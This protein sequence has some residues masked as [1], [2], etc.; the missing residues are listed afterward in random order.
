MKNNKLDP[1][2]PIYIISKGRAEYQYTSRALDKLGLKHRIAVEEHEY[3]L[4]AEALGGE[5]KL[6][7]LP[8]SNHGKGSGP[9]RNFCW[10][11][12]IEQGA[13]RHWL[14]DDN[15]F[16][17]SRFH[18]NKK[19]RVYTGSLF[20]S[21]E[22]FVDR[23]T[24]VALAGPQYA[25]FVA[26]SDKYAPVMLNS[27]LMSCIL[28]K[29]D[30]DFRWRCRYNED[31]DLS[32]RA[33]KQGYTTMVFYHLLQYKA[34]TQSI[35]GG[36]TTEL[37]GEGTYNKSKMLALLHPDCVR[38]VE[39]YGRV[40]HHVDLRPFQHILPILKDDVEIEPGVNEYGLKYVEGYGTEHQKDAIYV[41]RNR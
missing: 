6:L 29:N 38:V 23:Y 17:F 22:D 32:L 37:Y 15:I 41:P 12:S 36:N 14:M 35:P 9:A 1:K 7:A 18:H 33:L 11:H 5:E 3:D 28:I 34:N 27:R 31:V 39:R 40:H 13:E 21:I 26:H 30:L 2:Y 10:E 8:F 16:Y 4:Y 24:N 20:R 25:F 19:V